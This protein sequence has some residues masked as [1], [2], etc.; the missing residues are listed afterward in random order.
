MNFKTAYGTMSLGEID[1]N[2]LQIET[3]EE[4][5][6]TFFEVQRVSTDLMQKIQEAIEIRKKEFTKEV[7]GKFG[8]WSDREV[9]IDSMFLMIRTYKKK[10]QYEMMV[11]FFDQDDRIRET[12]VF[13]SVDLSEYENELK[14]SM[15]KAMIDKFF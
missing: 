13:V 2:D 1:L 14:K 3:G 10:L 6:M 11:N 12:E 7:R 15:I 4:S 5:V 8:D 9:V